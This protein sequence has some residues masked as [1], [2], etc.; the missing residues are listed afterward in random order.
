LNSGGITRFTD[1]QYDMVRLGIGLYGISNNDSEK[2]FLENVCTLKTIISQIK[3][4][5]NGDTVGYSRNGKISQTTKIATLPIGYADGFGRVLGNGNYSVYINNKKAPT[6]GNICMDMCMV[7]VTNLDCNEGD[8]V[9]I[10]GQNAPINEY[11]ISL[12]TIGYEALT[13]VSER[14]KRV[15][16]KD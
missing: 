8:E 15:Y 14:V 9:I 5:E 6:I 12:G 3:V 4:L 2:P 11:A 10:F 13:S 7:D 1:A 16:M